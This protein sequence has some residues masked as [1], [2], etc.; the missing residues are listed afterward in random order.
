MTIS[1]PIGRADVR[2]DGTTLRLLAGPPASGPPSNGIAVTP[3][4]VQLPSGVSL[5]A[6]ASGNNVAFGSPN[7]ETGMTISGASGRADVRFSGST[8]KLFASA[9]GIPSNGIS[10][11]GSTGDVSI[12]TSTGNLT[13]GSYSGN[14]A[15]LMVAGN[16]NLG[17][18][19]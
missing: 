13:L 15:K 8:L 9:G 5:A 10:I 7:S 11:S 2:F 12:G 1:G 18:S 6:T 19:A 17:L 16:S 14:V 3:T 4:G